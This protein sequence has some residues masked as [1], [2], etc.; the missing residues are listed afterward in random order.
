MPVKTSMSQHFDRA[1]QSIQENFLQ[2]GNN[3]ANFNTMPA[4]EYV[5]TVLQ[6]LLP[7]ATEE[8][9]PDF[10][11]QLFSPPAAVHDMASHRE[12]PCHGL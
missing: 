5:L 6:D 10:S 8:F 12:M 3:V 9:S 4:V 1:A 7:P 11:K 2:A